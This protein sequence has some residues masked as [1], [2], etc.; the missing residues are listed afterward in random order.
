M[1]IRLIAMDLDGTTLL[2][3]HCSFSPRLLHAL[4]RA[5]KESVFIVPAT[6]RPYEMLPPPLKQHPIWESYAIMGNGSQIRDLKNNEVLDS[7]VLS[8]NTLEA[9]LSVLAPLNLPIEF[10]ANGHLYLT[11]A[12]LEK[13]RSEPALSFHVNTILPR[14]GVIE[15][16]LNH[17][18][19]SDETRVEKVNVLCIPAALRKEL[20]QRLRLLPVSAVWSSESILEISHISATKGNALKKLCEAIGIPMDCTMAIGDSGNDISML[21]LAGLSVAMETAPASVKVVADIITKSNIQDGAAYAIEQ[22]VLGTN[23]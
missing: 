18:C 16:S 17:I 7:I 19:S 2:P 5:H 14:Y 10:S 6:G 4:E 15:E 21:Q 12:S 11:A 22:Y 9:L 13:Q 20:E 8:D 23:V 1:K 3:D